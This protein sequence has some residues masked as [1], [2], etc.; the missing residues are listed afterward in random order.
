ME[1]A[2]ATAYLGRKYIIQKAL[3]TLV[4]MFNSPHPYNKRPAVLLAQR[5]NIEKIIKNG[6]PRG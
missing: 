3:N 6:L 4:E 5:W 2:I 1:M